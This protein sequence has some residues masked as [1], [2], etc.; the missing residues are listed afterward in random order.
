M[1]PKISLPNKKSSVSR[2][3]DAKLEG[4]VQENAL[5][6]SLSD[7]SLGSE[8]KKLGKQRGNEPPKF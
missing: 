5:A 3:R 1:D 8:A 6:C 7:R 4:S 2:D